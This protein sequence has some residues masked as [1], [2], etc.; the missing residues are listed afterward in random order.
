MT[1]LTPSRLKFSEHERNE[2]FVVPENGTPFEALLDPAY[3]AH[4]ATS[5]KP[6]D[7]IIVNAED[8]SYHGRLLVRDAG[9]LYAKMARLSY[10]ELDEVEVQESSAI[11][12]GY[13]VKFRGP[14]QKWSVLRGSDLLKDGMSKA[15]ANLWLSEHLK[16]VGT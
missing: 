14:I 12:A 11:P 16:T 6:C 5:F 10:I 15:A 4:V 2:F 1:Q 8:G 9:K 7:E 3:W 13:A